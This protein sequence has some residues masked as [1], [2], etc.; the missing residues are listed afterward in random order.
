MNTNKSNKNIVPTKNKRIKSRTVKSRIPSRNN[1]IKIIYNK[2]YYGKD[3]LPITNIIQ[4]IDANFNVYMSMKEQ[5]TSLDLPS[6]SFEDFF[7]V[8][9]ILKRK[10]NVANIDIQINK[11]PNV[12]LNKLL[13]YSL[14]YSEYKNWFN[15]PKKNMDTSLLKNQIGKDLSRIEITINNVKYKSINEDTNSIKTDNFNIELMNILSK[16]SVIDLNLTNKI[17]ICLC[18]NILNFLTDLI[19][20]LIS[21]KIDPEKVIITKAEKNV[22][23]TLTKSQQN[24]VYNFKTKFYITKDGGIVDPEFTCGDIELIF[25]IDFKKNTYKFPK[26][27]CKYNADICYQEENLGALQGN[28]SNIDNQDNTN[29]TDNTDNTDSS[30]YLKY[31]IPIALGVGGIVATPFLLGALGGKNKKLKTKKLK[32]KKRKRISKQ[33]TKKYFYS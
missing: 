14:Y 22:L 21:K 7:I 23:I 12:S 33:K 30:K 8:D 4:Y 5:K 1:A 11:Q 26:F 16:F 9:N 20:I 2:D 29:N 24:I 18:Q 13:A 31:G 25:L 28:V 10:E 32:H 6:S 27:K 15:S 3:L 19:T 17:G